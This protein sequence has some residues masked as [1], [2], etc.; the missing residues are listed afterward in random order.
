MKTTTILFNGDELQVLTVLDGYDAHKSAIFSDDMC[1]VA[2][3]TNE[4]IYIDILETSN[5]FIEELDAFFAFL[6]D[7]IPATSHSLCA[8][9]GHPRD[10]CFCNELSET[11]KPDSAYRN[12]IDHPMWSQ[13]EELGCLAHALWNG[14][15]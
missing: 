11:Y 9:A 8:S 13:V 3:V 10:V 1:C 5:S 6:N 15:F 14:N 2:L 4:T 12:S 7:T